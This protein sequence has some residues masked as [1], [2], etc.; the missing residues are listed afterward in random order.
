VNRLAD[1]AA[2]ASDDKQHKIYIGV[3]SF[4][5]SPLKQPAVSRRIAKSL[6]V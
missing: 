2:K 4:C 3:M 5:Y 1:C 6:A